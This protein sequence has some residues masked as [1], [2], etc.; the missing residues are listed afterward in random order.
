VV[1]V[2]STA[3]LAAQQ[4][5]ASALPGWMA[6]CWRQS[7]V[8]QTVDEVWLNPGGGSLLGVS[9][10]LDGDSLRSYELMLIRPGSNGL[11]FEAS[12]SGQPAAAFLAAAATDSSITFQ[13]LTHDYPQVIR[14]TRRGDS[15]LAMITGTV[16]DRQRTINYAYGR[17]ACPGM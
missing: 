9:R 15:L 3:P 17:A 5:S 14:Y 2:L 12:P 16:R 4:G 7:A 1:L 8:G 10:S 13:N 11:V 6:G